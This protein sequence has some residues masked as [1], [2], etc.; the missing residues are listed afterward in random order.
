MS[1]VAAA[2]P[3]VASTSRGQVPAPAR[4]VPLLSQPRVQ[5]VM[6]PLLV[7]VVLVISLLP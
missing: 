1:T 5:R 3:G 7:G 2:A 6:Y 4:R